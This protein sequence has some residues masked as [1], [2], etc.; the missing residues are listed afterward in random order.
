MPSAL[1]AGQKLEEL[2][3]G[4]SGGVRRE[5][6]HV[7]ANWGQTLGRLWLNAWVSGSDPQCRLVGWNSCKGAVHPYALQASS[8][9]WINNTTCT[10]M[11]DYFSNHQRCCHEWNTDSLA[12]G[13]ACSPPAFGLRGSFSNSRPYK[14]NCGLQW[15]KTVSGLFF[16][17]LEGEKAGRG[18]N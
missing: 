2:H 14:D 4:A 6:S 17:I 18:W 12:C 7:G 3:G 15:N 11:C 5:N 13:P 1:C 9:G 10:Y 16:K 8:E